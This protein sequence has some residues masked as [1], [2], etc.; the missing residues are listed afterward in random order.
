ME[1]RR[2]LDVS[3]QLEKHVEAASG[4]KSQMLLTGN[5]EL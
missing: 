3:M 4:V 2:R 5:H 1:G